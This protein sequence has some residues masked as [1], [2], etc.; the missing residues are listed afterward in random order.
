[1]PEKTLGNMDE[2][3]TGVM[4]K[5]PANHSLTARAFLEVQGSGP[6]IRDHAH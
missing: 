1:M 4:N 3:I 2:A 6:C 5:S